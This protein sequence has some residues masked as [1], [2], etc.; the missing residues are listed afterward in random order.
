MPQMVGRSADPGLFWI[1]ASRMPL[2]ENRTLSHRNGIECT[3]LRLAGSQNAMSEV[4][5]V[6]ELWHETTSSVFGEYEQANI[7]SF[8]AD[9]GS[10]S[11]AIMLPSPTSIK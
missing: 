2:L 11:V 10:L 5:S 6:E 3:K 1:T 7:C 9:M 4:P 8:V